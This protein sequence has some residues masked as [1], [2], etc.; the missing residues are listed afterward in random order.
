MYIAPEDHEKVFKEISRVLQPGGRL[1]IWDVVFPSKKTDQRQLYV[2][3]PLHI[4]LPGKDIDTGYGVKFAEGQG[5]EH[6]VDLA[7]KTG[8]EVTSQK[9][10]KGW[11]YLELKKPA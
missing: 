1:L 5:L 10:A 11:F 4:K 9:Q 8:F 7:K 3:Y 2:H 6:F